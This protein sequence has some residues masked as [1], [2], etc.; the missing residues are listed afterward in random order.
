MLLFAHFS[1][2]W[3]STSDHDARKPWAA[4]PGRQ[5]LDEGFTRREIFARVP[6]ILCLFDQITIE[7]LC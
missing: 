3:A 2:H 7:G 5:P 6:Q 1:P 4:T